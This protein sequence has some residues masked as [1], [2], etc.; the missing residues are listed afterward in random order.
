MMR[1]LI[2]SL[3]YICCALVLGSGLVGFVGVWCWLFCN[4]G[5]FGCGLCVSVFSV[6]CLVV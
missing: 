5:V 3:A 4:L 2:V 1:F 6:V